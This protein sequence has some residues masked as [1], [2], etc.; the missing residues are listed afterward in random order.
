MK[1]NIGQFL[2]DHETL[3]YRELAEKYGY[4]FPTEDD[5]FNYLKEN[6]IFEIMIDEDPK[7]P[8]T[9]NFLVRKGNGYELFQ[10]YDERFKVNETYYDNLEEAVQAKLERM[11]GGLRGSTFTLG[12]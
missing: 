9:G 2:K 4:Q 11:I 8:I 5:I 10:F 3:Q 6:N 1:H 7:T 12:R